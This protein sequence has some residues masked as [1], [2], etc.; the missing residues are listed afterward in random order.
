MIFLISS[1]AVASADYVPK[2][3]TSCLLAANVSTNI[4]Q[5]TSIT[6]SAAPSPSSTLQRLTVCGV[7]NQDFIADHWNVT[8]FAIGSSPA[9]CIRGSPNWRTNQVWMNRNATAGSEYC[10]DVFTAKAK[11]TSGIYMSFLNTMVLND[12]Q[13]R[14]L[15]CFTL[16]D[17]L[18]DNID[19]ECNGSIYI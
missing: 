16:F 1:V 9:I 3:N 11:Q 7:A 19:K 14:N 10:I 13:N 4:W 12:S 15:G 5:P 8:G 2:W 17:S 6:V 18:D